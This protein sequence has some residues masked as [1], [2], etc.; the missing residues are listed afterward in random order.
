MSRATTSETIV[1]SPSSTLFTTVTIPTWVLWLVSTSMASVGGS[2]PVWFCHL[3]ALGIDSTFE[4]MNFWFHLPDFRKNQLAPVWTWIPGSLFSSLLEDFT[5]IHFGP[6]LVF[7][8][9]FCGSL[10]LLWSW[11]INLFHNFLRVQGVV[12]KLLTYHHEDQFWRNLQMFSELVKG[13]KLTIQFLT[14]QIYL[15][16]QVQS[17]N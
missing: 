16:T 1:I 2:A 3:I 14:G 10:I 17:K 4:V 8:C 11:F 7:S 6:F 5:N 12:L 15:V 9:Q 13:H